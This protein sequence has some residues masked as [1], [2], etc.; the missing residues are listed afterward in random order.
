MTSSMRRMRYCGVFPGMRHAAFTLVELLV[1]VAVII[2][3]LA[4]LLPAIGMARAS[5]R[6]KKC[7]SNQVQI[8]SSWAKA[9][10]RELVRGVQW[11]KRVGAYLEGAT[12]VL[13]CPDDSTPAQSTSFGFNSHAWRFS[14]P[15]A[16]RIVLLDYKQPE[17]NIVGRTVTYIDTE[18]AAQQAP[19]HFQQENV[20]FYD[21]HVGSYAPEKINPR[22]CDYYNRYWRPVAESNVPLEGCTNSAE[23]LP[24]APLP[25]TTSTG[26][27]TSANGSMS[28]STSTTTTTTT[29]TSTPSTS[30]TTGGTPPPY[31]PCIPPSEASGKVDKG[32]QWLIRHQRTDGGWSLIHSQQADCNGQ[33]PNDGG[34]NAFTGATGLAL[35]PLMGAGNTLSSGPYRENVCRGLNF[36]ISQ[37]DQNTG[38]LED[39]DS[40]DASTYA[41]LIATLALCEAVNQMGQTNS[42]GGCPSSGSSPC[43]I[44][45]QVLRNAAQKAINFTALSQKGDGGWHYNN[46]GEGDSSHI[47]WAVAS[48]LTAKIAG[49]DVS[50]VNPNVLSGPRAFLSTVMAN[51]IFD[52]G[53]TVGNYRYC[54]CAGGNY[55][56]H[57][58]SYGMLSEVLL[59]TPKNH[60]KIQQH[61][62]DPTLVPS[63]GNFYRNFHYAHLLYL[64]GG[65]QWTAW[66]NANQQ[67]LS[68]NQEVGGH[69]DG[70]WNSAV[71]IPQG[72]HYCTCLALLSLEQYFTRIQLGGNGTATSGTG[73]QPLQATV[74]LDYQSDNTVGIFGRVWGGTGAVTQ[75][76]TR[77]SGPGALTFNPANS[78]ST[79]VT[80]TMNAYGNYRVRLRVTDSAGQTVSKDLVFAYDEN[81]AQGRFVRVR[82]PVTP[83]QYLS[84]AEVRVMNPFN[85][86]LASTG[87]S[88]QSSTLN[89]DTS[90]AASMAK[91]GST[92]SFTQTKLEG[93]AWWM[94][95]LTSNEDIKRIE[96]V[97]RGDCCG[98]RLSGA[99]VELLSPSLSVVRS[100]TIPTVATGS[101]HTF[102]LP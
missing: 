29:S 44:S 4:L 83:S 82:L 88:Q 95:D 98:D 33:C 84:L 46:R 48:L 28:T 56:G 80:M 63:Y 67:Q 78:A 53:L 59:G 30:T 14:A 72:R 42:V 73:P 75:S 24:N 58:N 3:L 35:L 15:D 92:G 17:A 94:V 36:L 51:G 54:N 6:Q 27:T 26:A 9:N 90:L 57:Y 11:M 39:P 2:I 7:A 1:V 34:I 68:Q 32:L 52:Y 102:T 47:S 76:W 87:V 99:V 97:N 96:V 45:P 93:G 60:L 50:T 71:E 91:D 89:D 100:W 13:L 12:E 70:S 49:L 81:K 20:A 61:C 43:S 38:S 37:Q 31:D 55:G 21:G 40:F 8:Y 18:W 64:L 101:T 10:S 66:N 19:R 74:Q 69:K 16:G 65:A 85:R 41:H 79:V 62:N 5:A 77:V 25:G 86:N 23:A 22:Y